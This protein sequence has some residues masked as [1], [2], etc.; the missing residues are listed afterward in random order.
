MHQL[1]KI[2]NKIQEFSQEVKLNIPIHIRWRKSNIINMCQ[3]KG[4]KV[5]QR[6]WPSDS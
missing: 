5:N 1:L 3:E 6:G 4:E 2:Q